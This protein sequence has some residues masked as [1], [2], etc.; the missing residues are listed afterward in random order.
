MEQHKTGDLIG[1]TVT[2]TDGHVIGSVVEL[3]VDSRGWRVT[4]VQVTIEKNTAKEMGLK[5]PLFGGLKV[6][7]ETSRIKS[8]TDQIVLDL[9]VT[10]F[11]AYVDARKD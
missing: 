2:N 5:T 7:V 3:I 11:K 10:D 1:K 8:V 4:D 9:A 6:L